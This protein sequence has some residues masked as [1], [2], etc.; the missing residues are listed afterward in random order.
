MV[1]PYYWCP[2]VLLIPQEEVTNYHPRLHQWSVPD[3]SISGTVLEEP[4]VGGLVLPAN[5]ASI[6]PQQFDLVAGVACVPQGIPQVLS[7]T[8]V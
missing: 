4:A 2:A 3:V 1:T 5:V 6:F 8:R 7:W